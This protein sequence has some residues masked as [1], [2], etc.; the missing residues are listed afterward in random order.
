M[1]IKNCPGLLTEGFTEYSPR[2]VRRMF[3]GRRVSH[4]LPYNAPELD[5]EDQQLFMQNLKRISISGVQ[6]K[7][8]VLLVKNKLRLTEQGEA[9]TYILKPKPHGLIRASLVPANEHLTM[10]IAS[11]VYGIQ[12]A[13]NGIVFFKN[14][15]EF[16]PY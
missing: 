6:E 8:S 7:Y 11:Q 3:N 2:F 16:L 14:L 4:I 5:E 1:E 13:E 9:G 10:Q 15:A 12:T